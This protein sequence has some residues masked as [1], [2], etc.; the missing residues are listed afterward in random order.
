MIDFWRTITECNADATKVTSDLHVFREI[1]CNYFVVT[2]LNSFLS[3]R[4]NVLNKGLL[5]MVIGLIGDGVSELAQNC[6]ML[7]SEI[8]VFLLPILS[9]HH[10]SGGR[11]QILWHSGQWVSQKH[12]FPKRQDSSVVICELMDCIYVMERAKGTQRTGS[13][14]RA[15][16]P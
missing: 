3:K 8:W 11:S 2:M 4:M 5:V 15:C 9:L 10:G 12:C 7:G 16:C 14:E 13:G 1:K 6:S